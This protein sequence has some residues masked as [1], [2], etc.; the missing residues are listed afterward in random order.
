MD[1]SENIMDEVEAL[2]IRASEAALEIYKRDFEVTYKKDDT[3]SPNSPLTEADMTSHRIIV[4]GLEELTPEIPI[5]SEESKKNM[6]YE[7]R[8][9]FDRFWLVD[10]LDGTKEFVKK[11]GEFTINIGLVVGKTPRAGVVIAPDLGEIYR[12]DGEIAFIKKDGEKR[13][14][15]V[16]KQDQLA[17]ST[18]VCSRS[19]SGEKMKKLFEAVDF[20]QTLPTGSSLKFCQVAEGEAD[21]YCRFNPTWEWDT[22][23]GD[24]VA[25]AAGATVSRLDGKLLTYNKQSFK[26]ED[27]FLITNGLLHNDMLEAVKNIT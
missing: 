3:H 18:I 13:Q 2:A 24:A 19:H 26:N 22:A 27:G 11:N 6:S 15:S 7:K 16:S 23:A 21:V 10:P 4:E 9:D 25:R 14:I 17:G 1:I 12:T 8:K 20:G 5:I